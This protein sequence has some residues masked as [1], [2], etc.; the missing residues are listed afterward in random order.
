M[1]S[2]H[3]KKNEAEKEK[4][5]REKTKT[6]EKKSEIYKIREIRM[7]KKIKTKECINENKIK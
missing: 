6:Q 5:K 3:R 1:G 4:K 2:A 7:K